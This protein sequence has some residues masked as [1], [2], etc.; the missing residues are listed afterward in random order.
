MS[1]T[2]T[3]VSRRNSGLALPGAKEAI[4]HIDDVAR[5]LRHPRLAQNQI[6]DR[7]HDTRP[8][9]TAAVAIAPLQRVKFASATN[10]PLR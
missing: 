5:D 3:V 9:R 4:L 2:P 7:L 6:R 10:A 1:H 8:A